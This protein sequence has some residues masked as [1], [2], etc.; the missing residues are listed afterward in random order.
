MS[1]LT[2]TEKYLF[3]LALVGLVLAYYAGAVQLI[4]VG[5]PQLINLTEVAQ[6]RTTQGTYPAYPGNA[7]AI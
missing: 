4:K 5:G 1:E 7:P 3:I 6:G 2:R